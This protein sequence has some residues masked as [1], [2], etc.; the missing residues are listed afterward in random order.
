MASLGTVTLS[1][2]GVYDVDIVDT[3]GVGVA[4][5]EYV[6]LANYVEAINGLLYMQGAG[7]GTLTRQVPPGGQPPSAPIGIGL[8]VLVS[9][10]EADDKH[11][12]AVW[13]EPDDDGPPLFNIAGA[14]QA[15]PR[16]EVDPKLA[17]RTV[18]GIQVVLPPAPAGRYRVMARVGTG[19]TA[20]TRSVHFEIRDQV[21]AG[22]PPA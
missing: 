15:E 16:P 12:F 14:F 18:V 22:L 19:E 11:D 8:S 13:V 10:A 5:V 2:R 17:L 21:A 6:T 9:R 4:T 20:S 1:R 7:W 3:K